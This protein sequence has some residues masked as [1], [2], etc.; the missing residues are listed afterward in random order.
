MYVLI[1]ATRRHYGCNEGAKIKSGNFVSASRQ[2][3]K[4]LP[5]AAGLKDE[6]SGGSKFICLAI[7]S[8]LAKL[9]CSQ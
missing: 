6:V 1:V 9:L 8:L 5:Q 2:F 4:E 7:Y 3:H